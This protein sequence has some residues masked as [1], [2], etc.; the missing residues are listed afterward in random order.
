MP[1]KRSTPRT[2]CP[3]CHRIID[4]DR[5]YQRRELITCPHCNRVLEVIRVYP[6]ELDLPLDPPITPTGRE[7][8]R[9]G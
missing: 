5:R 3:S 4:L 9:T 2:K 8:H 1:E 6:Q 7:N